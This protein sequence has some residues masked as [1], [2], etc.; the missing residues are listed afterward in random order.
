MFY[1][2]GAWQTATTPIIN[3]S[4]V[5]TKVNCHNNGTENNNSL[6]NPQTL[7]STSSAVLDF[8]SHH[9]IEINNSDAVRNFPACEMKY[10]EYTPCQ[11]RVRGRKF[12][13]KILKYRE[14]H[15]PQTEELLSCLI[16]TPPKYKNP[17]KWPKSRDY[18]WFDNIPHKELSIEKFVQNWIQVEGDRF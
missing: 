14:R 6:L 17:F 18:A 2:L 10:S 5:S 3:R 9:Q 4:D 1:I 13:R 15:C 8:D 12:D 7:P 11:D 16:P